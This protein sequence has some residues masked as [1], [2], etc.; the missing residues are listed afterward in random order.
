MRN[1]LSLF[2]VNMGPKQSLFEPNNRGRKS[3]DT[4]LLS[5]LHLSADREG[6]VGGL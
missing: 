1:R 6:L 3:R 4:V 5:G 2:N